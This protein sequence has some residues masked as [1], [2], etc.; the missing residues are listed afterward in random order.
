MDRFVKKAVAVFL[1]VVMLL[2]T[3]PVVGLDLW[4]GNSAVSA[5]D[6]IKADL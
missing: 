4:F 2:S 5:V 3:A 6:E 1:A